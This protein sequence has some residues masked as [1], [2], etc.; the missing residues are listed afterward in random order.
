MTNLFIYDIDIIEVI[1]NIIRKRRKRMKNLNLDLNDFNMSD[2]KDTLEKLKLD[3]L[4]YCEIGMEFNLT[5]STV[6]NKVNYIK[7]KLKK[8]LGDLFNE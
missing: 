7:T 5:S 3:V 2:I 4:V 8:D 6:S 1:N